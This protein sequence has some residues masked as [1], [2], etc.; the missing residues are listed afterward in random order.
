MFKVESKLL[1]YSGPLTPDRYNKFFYPNLCHVCKKGDNGNFLTC[2]HCY[3]ILYCCTNHK[4]L[5]YPEHKQICEAL[6]KHLKE[7]AEWRTRE[8]HQN[9][10]VQSRLLFLQLIQQKMSRQLEVYEMEMITF[11][12]SCYTCHRQVNLR[13]CPK[14]YSHNYCVAHAAMFENNHKKYC[15]TLMISVNLDIGHLKSTSILLTS[16][17][18]IELD[19][20]IKGMDSFIS[21]FMDCKRSIG[22]EHEPWL[23]Q[24]YVCSDYASGPLTLCH[25]MAETGMSYQVT[26]PESVIHII[27]GGSLERHY[28]SAWEFFLHIF[29]QIKKLTIVFA[30]PGLRDEYNNIDVCLKCRAKYGQQLFFETHDMS[31]DKY[32]DDIKLYKRPNI[33][34]AF[35]AEFYYEP[36]AEEILKAV[37]HQDQTLLITS[38]SQNNLQKNMDTIDRL[39]NLSAFGSSLGIFFNNFSSFRPWRDYLTGSTHYRNAFYNIY[40][41]YADNP[42]KA[43][44]GHC[45]AHR[46]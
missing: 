2:D 40:F 24:D 30:G 34:L 13:T 27:T 35:Q 1:R 16:C 19:R 25:V 14:C 26:G 9:E 41:R 8:L 15:S 28:L 3:M 36:K 12:K 42:Y 5:H 29:R 33:I 43:H 44:R 31:Y 46:E 20:D 22:N 18:F 6:E 10:W 37:K 11:A 17:K 7:D 45:R 4:M 38:T 32:V 23:F 21:R 39:L